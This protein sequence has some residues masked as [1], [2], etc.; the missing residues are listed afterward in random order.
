MQRKKKRFLM[1]HLHDIFLGIA[2][3]IHIFIVPTTI[4]DL[5]VGEGLDNK[6]RLDQIT[7]F[8]FIVAFAIEVG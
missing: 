2:C 3:L 4:F 1:E 6:N 8:H 7:F 5:G